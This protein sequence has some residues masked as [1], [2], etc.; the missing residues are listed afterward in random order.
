M[1]QDQRQIRTTSRHAGG[2]CHL[3][4]RQRFGVGCFQLQRLATRLGHCRLRR[5]VR[6]S[7]YADGVA[8]GAEFSQMFTRVGIAL[9]AS[10][11][12]GLFAGSGL[13][14][15]L[16]YRGVVTCLL[17][18]ARC[19]W[20]WC[21]WALVE[22]RPVQLTSAPLMATLCLILTDPANWRSAAGSQCSTAPGSV[23]TVWSRSCSDSQDCRKSAWLQDCFWR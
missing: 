1:G 6:L 9:A 8:G 22:T 23:T 18:L 15:V 21:A 11:A 19:L 14:H 16:G 17:L 3:C 4:H 20:L 12:L 13:V 5:S 10:P 7:G 2:T